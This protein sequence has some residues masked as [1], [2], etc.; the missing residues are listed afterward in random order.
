VRA[1][2]KIPV[3]G[4]GDVTKAADIERMKAHTGCPAV[5]IGRAAIGNPWIFSHTDR[6]DVPVEKVHQMVRQHLER[7][8]AY[9]G[10]RKGLLLFRKHALQYLK[11]QHL[12][13]ATRT[14][15]LMQTTVDGF[16]AVVDEIY[17]GLE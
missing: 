15:A 14:K 9:Y 6:D 17:A 12:T 16:L 3:I 11:L 5:M 2:L 8:L 13:R 1:A 10:P 4:S 7:N